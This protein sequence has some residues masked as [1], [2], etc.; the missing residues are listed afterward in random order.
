MHFIENWLLNKFLGKVALRAA[1]TI[2]AYVAG[3]DIQK[4][5]QAAGIP[6]G[7]VDP[8]KMAEGF[9]IGAHFLL[10]AYKHW[11]SGTPAGNEAAATALL[12]RAP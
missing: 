11:R 2:A 3:P 4:F 6:I 10:E 5:V 7:P 8:V 1:V 9:A 12:T